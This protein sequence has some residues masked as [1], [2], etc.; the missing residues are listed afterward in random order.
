MHQPLQ[1][2]MLEIQKDTMVL[3]AFNERDSSYC[4]VNN[5][6]INKNK[7]DE[8]ILTKGKL[9]HMTDT[10]SDTNRYYIEIEHVYDTLIAL[11]NG[12]KFPDPKVK[13]RYY[14]KKLKEKPVWWPKIIRK[15]PMVSG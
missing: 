12:R 14:Y 11:K 2:F 7:N 4:Y 6:N 3:H 10:T 13:V 1:F 5:I 9:A 8:I 15:S